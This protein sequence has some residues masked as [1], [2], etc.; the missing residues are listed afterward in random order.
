MTVRAVLFDLDGTLVDSVPALT[1]GLNDV[2]ATYGSTLMTEKAVADLVGKGVRKLIEDVF[3]VKHL[4]ALCGSKRRPRQSRCEVLPRG[5]GRCGG[6][7]PDGGEDRT[8]HQQV[9]R[10]GGNLRAGCGTRQLL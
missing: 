1:A 8:R 7:A 3:A 10:D 6:T 9:P 4:R 5:V 2:L